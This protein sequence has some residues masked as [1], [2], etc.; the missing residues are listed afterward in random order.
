M[1]IV[2]VISNNR[3]K[4]IFFDVKSSSFYYC[5]NELILHIIQK[6]FLLNEIDIKIMMKKL[7]Y[8]YAKLLYVCEISMF[9]YVMWSGIALCL[10]LHQDLTFF[11]FTVFVSTPL[12]IHNFEII[13][14]E[15]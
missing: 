5:N 2:V 9:A 3:S 10:F 6:I 11:L 7:T 4:C 13:S 14:G 1:T 12:L 8:T 15:G